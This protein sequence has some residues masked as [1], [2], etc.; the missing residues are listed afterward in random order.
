MKG[1][2]GLKLFLGAFLILGFFGLEGSVNDVDLARHMDP[3]YGD[4][5]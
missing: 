3:D 5:G 4:I 2:L 1:K